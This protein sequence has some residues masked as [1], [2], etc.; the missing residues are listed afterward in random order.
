MSKVLLTGA[1]GNLGKY[2]L[3]ELLRRGHEI[4]CFDL[5]TKTNLKHARQYEHHARLVWGDI[6]SYKEISEPVKNNDVIIHLA[7]LIPPSSE[8]N[9]ELAEKVNLQGTKNIVDAIQL[10]LP[11]PQ[12]LF[13]SSVSVYG[14]NRDP[15]TRRTSDDQLEASDHYTSHKI[16]SEEYIKSQLQNWSILRLGVIPP[17]FQMKIEPAMYDLPLDTRIHLLPPRDGAMAF[18]NSVDNLAVR[19]KTLLIGGNESCQTTYGDYLGRVFNSLGLSL[20]QPG[21]FTKQQYYSYWMDTT[22]SQQ[23]LHYQQ[24]SLDEYCAEVEHRNRWI[25]PLLRPLSPAVKWLMKRQSRYLKPKE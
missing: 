9:P 2:T 22:E 6:T 13:A 23:L 18:A 25:R 7:A 20:P 21:A 4:T 3:D 5:P 24:H 14:R 16:Q 19:Q 17:P 1:F 8:R 10:Q 12:L 11:Q 15:S